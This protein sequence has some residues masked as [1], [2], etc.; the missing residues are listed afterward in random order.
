MKL[1]FGDDV[2]SID[3]FAMISGE[4]ERIQ[5]SKNLKAR[6]QVEEWLTFVLQDMIKTL[7]R[8]LGEGIIDYVNIN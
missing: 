3:I 4:G 6:G 2:N 8:L 5:L 1:D 7:K